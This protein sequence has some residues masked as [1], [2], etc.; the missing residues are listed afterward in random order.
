MESNT[1]ITVQLT[2]KKNRSGFGYLIYFKS[3]LLCI[4]ILLLYF[5][6]RSYVIVV[7]ISEDF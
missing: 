7:F 3:L 4:I 2:F 1:F 5:A 6:I